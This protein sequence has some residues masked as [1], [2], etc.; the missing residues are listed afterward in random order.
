LN[1]KT[2]NMPIDYAKY[3]SNWKTKIRPDILRRAN[4]RC[5]FCLVQNYDCVFRGYWQGN[6]VY[7]VAEG[8][9]YDADSGKCL[10][11][12]DRGAA[13][14]VEPKSGNPNQQ[15]IKIVL[16]IMHLDHDITNNCYSNLAAGCQ[17]CHNR[18]DAVYRARNRKKIDNQIELFDTL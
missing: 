3:P 9:I 13:M 7:Q 2:K 10:Y 17:R 11:G 8:Y 12:G 15:A 6:E 5:E 1:E 4:N 18:H 16:T 14:N